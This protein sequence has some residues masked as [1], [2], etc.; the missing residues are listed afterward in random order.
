MLK[1][2]SLIIEPGQKVALVGQSGSGKSTV[3]QLLLRLYE[4]EE[5]QILLD[6]VDVRD[7]NLRHLREV[8][9]VTCS[10]LLGS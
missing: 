9:I 2:F 8:S 4:F 7:I 1:N 6:G 5:G 10:F 3:F